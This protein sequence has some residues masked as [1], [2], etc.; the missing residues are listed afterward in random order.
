MNQIEWSFSIKQSPK[1]PQANVWK[2][3]EYA[4]YVSG[5]LASLD[6]IMLWD[7]RAMSNM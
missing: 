7:L 2:F 5:I 4:A 1:F 3:G 6:L